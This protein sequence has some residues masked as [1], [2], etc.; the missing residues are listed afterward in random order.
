MLPTTFD[1]TNISMPTWPVYVSKLSLNTSCRCLLLSL[2][3]PESIPAICD[4][5]T[6]VFVDHRDASHPQAYAIC[7][8][9]SVQSPAGWSRSTRPTR[10]PGDAKRVNNQR[11]DAERQKKHNNTHCDAA[12]RRQVT[13]K[14]HRVYSQ[15]KAVRHKNTDSGTS[16]TETNQRNKKKQ[17]KERKQRSTRGKGHVGG[18]KIGTGMFGY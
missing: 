1:T 13:E 9:A 10:Q 17:R 16:A 12:L 6:A 3:P 4:A 8:A 14:A 5:Y 18:A 7:A 11:P 15:A 2:F